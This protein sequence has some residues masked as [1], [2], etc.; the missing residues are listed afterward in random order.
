MGVGVR[1]RGRYVI[2]RCNGGRERERER[3]REM[4]KEIE[5][6]V[7]CRSYSASGCQATR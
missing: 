2:R 7:K 4:E 1:D 5:R 6:G 3:E